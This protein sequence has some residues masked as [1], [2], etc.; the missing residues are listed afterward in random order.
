MPKIKYITKPQDYINDLI[1]H[2]Q[3]N[4]KPRITNEKLAQRVGLS[5]PGIAEK[6]SRGSGRYT[7]DYLMSVSRAL[8]IPTAQLLEAVGKYYEQGRFPSWRK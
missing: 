6:K 2:Y 8:C 3:Y 4:A 7:V 1:C 5:L